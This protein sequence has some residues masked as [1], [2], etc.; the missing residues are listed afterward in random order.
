MIGIM[1]CF[2]V[3]LIS[4]NLVVGQG[5]FGA[6]GFRVLA[7]RVLIRA[8]DCLEFEFRFQGVTLES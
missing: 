1:T 7:F 6:Q 8:S 5:F 4:F 2:V 3:V